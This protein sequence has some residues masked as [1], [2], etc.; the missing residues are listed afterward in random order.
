MKEF[1][2]SEIGIVHSEIVVLD[3]PRFRVLKRNI[4]QNNEDWREQLV[5]DR[6]G[7]DY[8]VSLAITEKDEFILVKTPKY[9]QLAEMVEIPTSQM[10]KGESANT[11]ANRILTERTGYKAIHWADLGHTILYESPDKIAGGQ[12]HLRLGFNAKKV[13]DPNNCQLL[14]ISRKQAE[15]I[16]DEKIIENKIEIAMSLSALLLAMRYLDRRHNGNN[17]S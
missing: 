4:E 3:D 6:R 8:A 17:H 7:T 15:K 5:W 13:S 12:H 9:G 11:A 10:L 1:T 16:I 14:L 2:F